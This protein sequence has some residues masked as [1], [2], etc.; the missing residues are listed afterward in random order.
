MTNQQPPSLNDLPKLQI[1]TLPCNQINFFP[2]VESP[3]AIPQHTPGRCD[4]PETREQHFSDVSALIKRTH[5]L[6]SGHELICSGSRVSASHAE[7]FVKRTKA[8]SRSEK[9]LVKG[10]QGEKLPAYR[11]NITKAQKRTKIPLD[12][13]GERLTPAGTCPGPRRWLC[14]GRSHRTAAPHHA[15]GCGHRAPGGGCQSP[16]WM[17]AGTS[18]WC[19]SSARTT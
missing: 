12:G 13:C 3:G 19:S 14:P 18:S 16:G 17:R 11:E 7:P 10:N 2:P 15:W 4:I 5:T 1:T 9:E 6:F 8:P